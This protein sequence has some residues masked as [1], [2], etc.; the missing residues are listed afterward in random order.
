MYSKKKINFEEIMVIVL[1]KLIVSHIFSVL[2]K[3]IVKL[4]FICE[5]APSCEIKEMSK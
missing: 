3:I 1:S 4:S 2:Q 5:A